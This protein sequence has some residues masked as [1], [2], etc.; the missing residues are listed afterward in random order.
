VN[1]E[2]ETLAPIDDL[3]QRV[4]EGEYVRLL[5]YPSGH[6]LAD[7][8]RALS[9]QARHWYAGHGRPWS[10]V[11]R[12]EIHN[13]DEDRLRVREHVSLQSR[14]LVDR[15]RSVEA[16]EI[17]V[18]TSTAGPEIDEHSAALW[19]DDCPDEAYFADRFGAAVVEHLATL[20]ATRLRKRF[21]REGLGMMPG[22]SPGYD[23]W[24]LTDQ[25]PLFRLLDP[26][27]GE[28]PAGMTV[29]DS[30]MLQPKNS[31]LAVFGIS[32]HPDLV[33]PLWKRSRCSWCSLSPCALRVG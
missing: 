2:L 16:T 27:G 25:L 31:L 6:K 26:Q 22:Y 17:L 11:R 28:L 8:T 9:L 4:D 30:G 24:S 15:L 32:P 19:S 5:G 12:L 29:L 33:E 10:A 14:T 23:G 21:A 13:L 3:A 18:A 20:T 1:A 7:A